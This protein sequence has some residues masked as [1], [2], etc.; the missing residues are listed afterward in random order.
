MLKEETI[1]ELKDVFSFETE[2][3]EIIPDKAPRVEIINLDLIRIYIYDRIHPEHLKNII[4]DILRR[5]NES[6]P[7]NIH[8]E[9]ATSCKLTFYVD[10][11][12]I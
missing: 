1:Q 5:N 11:S 4:F 6:G 8:V 10:I 3:S 7:L 12:S 2:I 9:T